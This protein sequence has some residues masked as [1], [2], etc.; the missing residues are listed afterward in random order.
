MVVPNKSTLQDWKVAH[1]INDNEDLSS[2]EELHDEILKEIVKLGLAAKVTTIH[3]YLLIIVSLPV[4]KFQK[5]F[6]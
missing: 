6:F 3:S 5:E 2:N 1:K 4:M